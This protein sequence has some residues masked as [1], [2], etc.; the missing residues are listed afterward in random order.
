MDLELVDPE[1]RQPLRR[2]SRFPLNVASPFGRNIARV[3]TRLMPAA[4]VEGVRLEVVAVGPISVRV[5]RPDVVRTDAA[6]LWIHGGGLVIGAAKMDDRL[7]G[8]T[9]RELGMVVVSPDYRLAPEHPF[10]EPLDDCTVGWRWLANHAEDLGVD[11]ERIVVGGQSAGGGLAAAL[12]QRLHDEGRTPLAQWL[13]CPMLDDRTSAVVPDSPSRYWVWDERANNVGW[14]AYL[15]GVDAEASPYAVPARRADLTGLPAAWIYCG[16]I[17]LF[18][19]E[20]VDYARRLREAGV[21]V[22][23]DVV[24]GVPHGFEAWASGTAPALALLERARRWLADRVA[25][26]A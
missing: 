8:E 25:A 22:V 2:L 1:V 13:F 19:D 4:K 26:A 10:P 3:G 9:A 12:V 14:A 7:C 20:D 6:L 11:V 23:L 16:D 18:H 21:D 5:Y 17:E 24:S 15:G